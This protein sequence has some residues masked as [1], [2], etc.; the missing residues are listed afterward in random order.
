MIVGVISATQ[1]LKN[2]KT[3]AACIFSPHVLFNI[4]SAIVKQRIS[5]T[6]LLDRIVTERQILQIFSTPYPTILTFFVDKSHQR[7]GVGTQLLRA[8]LTKLPKNV[9][10]FVDTEIS[11][12]NAT[13]WYQARGFR[14]QKIINRSIVLM[15]IPPPK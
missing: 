3:D 2:T 1:D 6:E 13:R 15:L 8:L 9:P 5:I 14:K 7:Q 12:V 11:N 10:V 4:A